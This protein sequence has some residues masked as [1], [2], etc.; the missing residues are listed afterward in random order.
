MMSPPKSVSTYPLRKGVSLCRPA[1]A[2]C[3]L[4]DEAPEPCIHYAPRLRA[5]NWRAF[6]MRMATKVLKET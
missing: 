6:D 1:A 5:S 4:A 2:A 3:T